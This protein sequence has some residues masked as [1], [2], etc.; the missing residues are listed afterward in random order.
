MRGRSA[1]RRVRTG[2]WLAVWLLL[3]SGCGAPL[4]WSRVLQLEHPAH[5][6]RAAAEIRAQGRAGLDVLVQAA[7]SVSDEALI[8][9]AFAAMG[10]RPD[11]QPAGQRRPPGKAAARMAVRWLSEAPALADELAGSGEPAERALSLISRAERPADLLAALDGLQAESSPVVLSAGFQVV[12]CAFAHPAELTQD[13]IQALLARKI[14]IATRLQALSERDGAAPRSLACEDPQSIPSK[15]I[16]D[17]LL[18]GRLEVGPAHASR[19]RIH[20][21]LRAERLTADVQPA[22]AVWLYDRA[23]EQGEVYPGLLAP[24]VGQLGITGAEIRTRAA[25]LLLRDLDR[26]PEADR[27]RLLVLAINA[28]A[29]TEREL[30][31]DPDAPSARIEELEAAAR[32]GSQPARHAIEHRLLCRGTQSFDGRGAVALLGFMPAPASADLAFEM[33]QRCPGAAAGALSALLRL[34]DPR[35]VQM[36]DRILASG[37]ACLPDGIVRA[38]AEHPA[39]PVRLR[40]EEAARQGNRHA[41]RILDSLERFSPGGRS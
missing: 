6:A 3:C 21:A 30:A 1:S 28:G 37:C 26:Y 39:E 24:L 18:A 34:G 2:L 23:A 15:E 17:S 9:Q 19:D 4:R 8:E 40:L 20:I 5:G 12:D 27:K 38:I 10:C 33:G 7:R 35:A 29:Q 16:L 14:A 11:L 25:E 13:R 32:R 22:C 31:I 41:Q 36:L